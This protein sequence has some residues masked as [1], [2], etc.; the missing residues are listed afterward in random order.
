MEDNQAETSPSI[1]ARFEQNSASVNNKQQ[2]FY[3][4]ATTHQGQH[5]P[6]ILI[7]TGSNIN[8]IDFK[9]AHNL[10]LN[11][12]KCRSVEIPYGNNSNQWTDCMATL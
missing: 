6:P 7:D 11:V 10:R 3:V 12:D 8:T 4:E 9:T 1:F 2:R 5:L